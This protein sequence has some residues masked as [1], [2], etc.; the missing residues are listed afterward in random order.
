MA[1]RSVL[2]LT[3]PLRL[4]LSLLFNLS[5]LKAYCLSFSMSISF[6]VVFI[7]LTLQRYDGKPYATMFY[8]G[9]IQIIALFLTYIKQLCTHTTPFSTFVKKHH[10]RS[11][12]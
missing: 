10:K 7:L 3:T 8:T 6:R 5:Y 9:E 1:S 2:G 11:E 12:P 4:L